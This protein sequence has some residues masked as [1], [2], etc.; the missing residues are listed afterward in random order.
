MRL[1]SCKGPDETNYIKSLALPNTADQDSGG[2]D[3]EDIYRY[4]T[5]ELSDD[6]L[7]FHSRYLAE[8]PNLRSVELDTTSEE[9]AATPY[10]TISGRYKPWGRDIFVGIIDALYQR[11]KETSLTPVEK[12]VVDGINPR[13]MF[14]S[15]QIMEKAR[16]GM[17]QLR[18]VEFILYQGLGQWVFLVGDLLGCAQQLRELNISGLFGFKLWELLVPAKKYYQLH[19]PKATDIGSSILRHWTQLYRVV[20]HDIHTFADILHLFIKSHKETL[21]SLEISCHLMDGYTGYLDDLNIKPQR[22][23]IIKRN[24]SIW[25]SFFRSLKLLDMKDVEFQFEHLTQGFEGRTGMSYRMHNGEANLWAAWVMG[26]RNLEPVPG[27]VV[28]CPPSC[29]CHAPWERSSEFDTL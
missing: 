29:H 19:N 5:Y 6:L 1:I 22:P 28:D 4:I 9:T 11:R 26:Q 10:K 2:E 20:L 17:A 23:T 3:Y 14:L 27:E 12:L 24:P 25:P 7:S 8:L 21:G 18:K 15:P 13:M 16:T